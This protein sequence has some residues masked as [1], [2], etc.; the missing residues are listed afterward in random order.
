MQILEGLLQEND[1]AVHVYFL[2]AMAY[3]AGG[4]DE[5]ALEYITEGEKV[6]ERLAMPANDPAVQG[7]ESLRVSFLAFC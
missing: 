7:F 3:H 2:L 4:Q 5:S 6:I 1:Q